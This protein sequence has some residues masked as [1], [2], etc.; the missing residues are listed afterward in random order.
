MLESFEYSKAETPGADQASDGGD[1]PA[2]DT[3]ST[4]SCARLFSPVTREAARHVAETSGISRKTIELSG[5]AEI[6]LDEMRGAD[7]VCC[8]FLRLTRADHGTVR[9]VL[10]GHHVLGSPE[11][12]GWLLRSVRPTDPS[13]WL[14]APPTVRRC[15]AN[16]RILSEEVAALDG[17]R[18]APDEYSVDFHIPPDTQLDW[19]IWRIDPAAGALL[20]ELEFLRTIERQPVF[21]WSSH[22]TYRRPADVYAHLIHGLVYDNRFV[23][24]R[25]W[26]RFN[27]RINSEFEAYG[28]YVALSGLEQ[29]TGKRIYTLLKRQI[30]CA[31]IARQSDDGGWYHG[32]WTDMM[33]CHFRFHNGAMLLLAAALE[34]GEDAVVRASLQK[35]AAF[36]A[37]RTDRTDLG[38]WFLHDSLE[39]SSDTM[40][41][42]GSRWTPSR[43]LGKSP[44]TKMVLNT[45]LDAIVTLDRYREVS[46]DDRHRQQVEAALGTTRALLALRPAEWLYRPLFWCIGQTLLPGGSSGRTALARRVL[47]RLTRKYLIPRLYKIKRRFP[48]MV[49]PGGLI[50]RHLSMPHWGARY[51][52]VNLMDLL[53]LQRRFPDA[54]TAT[55][56]EAGLRAVTDTRL[57]DYWVETNEKQALGYW[58][59]TLYQLCTQDPAAEHRDALARAM[60]LADDAGL[61][62]PPSLLGAN[63]EVVEAPYR[64]PC[65]SPTEATLRIANLSR[66]GCRELLVVNCGNQACVPSWQGNAPV[67][68]DWAGTQGRIGVIG[69]GGTAPEIPPRGWLWGYASC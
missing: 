19:V 29:A 56:I 4:L 26:G 61:G 43:E 27:W 12:G 46:G 49:M 33:E 53:R 21:M 28:L 50:E 14:P 10:S 67:G 47:R 6:V 1:R 37:G 32:E 3:A 69:G 38:P 60:L 25:K 66:A 22:A 35:A 68:L 15:D 57:L 34:E 24:H 31:V 64:L 7:G 55:V 20:D 17:F 62:L 45:H 65:P 63:A 30:V 40:A 13:Y 8:C 5:V 52:T 39:E 36:I 18:S 54:A 41:R 59:E 48:R 23:W 9:L 42:S 51:Q 58:V 2:R 44:S 16:G 11:A